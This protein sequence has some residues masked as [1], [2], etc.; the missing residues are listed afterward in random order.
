MNN[1]HQVVLV[2]G[3]SSGIGQAVAQ[4]M[5]KNGYIVYGTS[6]RAA[7]ET[8]EN[9]GV[10][11]VMVPMTLEDEASVKNAVDYVL[12]RH[13]RIDVLVNN[14]GLGTAGAIEETT[15]EEAFL[16]F[17]AGYFGIIRVLNHVLPHMRQAKSGTVI[18][19][20]SVSSYFP[21]PFQ[22]VYSNMKAAVFSLTAVLR[23]ELK[24]FG[25]NVCAVE[26][27]NTRTNIIKS[28]IYAE[29]TAHTAYRQP[30]ERALTTVNSNIYSYGPEKC[31]KVVLK[32]AKKKNP[33]ARVTVGFEYKLIHAVSRFVPWCVVEHF[34]RKVYLYKSPQ[35]GT[36]WTFD[37][38]F[39]N[40]R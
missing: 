13:G 1:H 38:Q 4:T 14:A 35:K 6:R 16:Q 22:G 34:I 2:T 7:Y 3:A 40:S 31:A 36:T 21:V 28:R 27:G 25:V 29:K 33:P 15:A 18:N 9:G 24:P 20:G 19:I 11:Y 30:L 26:P 39:K 8:V 23:F 37:G 17:N 5:A 32:M 10:R 12:Q